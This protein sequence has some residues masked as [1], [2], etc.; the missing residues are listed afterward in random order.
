M[1]PD[2]V[3]GDFSRRLHQMGIAETN[4]EYNASST[5]APQFNPQFN[6]QAI[7]APTFPPSRFN[8][9]LTA[10]EARA[11]LQEQATEDFEAS[12]RADVQ[13]RRFLNIRTLADAVQLRDQGVPQRDIE[14]RLR[15]QPGLL[16]K[17][18]RK[19]VLSHINSPN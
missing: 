1:D 18:G 12:G 14:A 9:T 19:D 6:P 5:A 15:I 8:P 3:T 13:G 10:L 2:F 11:R 16:E 7:S 17:L 4:T